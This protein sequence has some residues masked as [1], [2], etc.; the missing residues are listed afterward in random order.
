MSRITYDGQSYEC[1]TNTVLQTLTAH[2]VAIPSSCHSGLCQTCMMQATSGT[3]PEAAQ[4]GIKP[5]LVAQG[6]FLA[7]ICHPENDLEIA[8]PAKGQEKIKASVT[9]IERLNSD[10]LGIRLKPVSKFDYRAG[11]FINFYLDETTARSYSLASVPA[12]D[13]ELY[14]NVRKV[15][16]GLVSGWIFDNLKT[17]DSITISEAIGDCFYLPGNASQDILLIGTGSGLAPLYGII[18][19]ALRQGHTGRIKLYHGSYNAAGLYFVSE[20][21]TLAK[22]YANFEYVPCVSAEDAPPP[23]YSQGIVLDVALRDNPN[24]KGWRVFL[25]GNPDM[26][27]AAK[28]ET[29]LAGVSM[30]DIH[31]DPFS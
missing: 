6:H 7:C 29:Y 22:E 13:E 18:R 5:T 8:L 17:G 28:R 24:L 1:G 12:L 15:P 14:L 25:C 30:H 10:I 3:V 19:D 9:S 4:A 2:G 23:G 21:R 20:L 27:N 31:A 16:G 11:Q 26:V